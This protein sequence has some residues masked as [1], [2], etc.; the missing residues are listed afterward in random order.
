MFWDYPVRKYIPTQT[1]VDG[2]HYHWTSPAWNVKG[3]L[4][5]WNKVKIKDTRLKN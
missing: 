2:V 4:S 1:K 3:S 5:N